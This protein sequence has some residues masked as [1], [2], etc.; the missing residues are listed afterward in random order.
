MDELLWPLPLCGTARRWWKVK[1]V[2]FDLGWVEEE[3]GGQGSCLWAGRRKR[4]LSSGR[5]RG[6]SSW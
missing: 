1:K 4:L 6:S 3:E 2:L 5:V